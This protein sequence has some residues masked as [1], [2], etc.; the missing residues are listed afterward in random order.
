MQEHACSCTALLLLPEKRQKGISLRLCA[1][2]LGTR[3]PLRELSLILP[4]N[5]VDLRDALAVSF[6]GDFG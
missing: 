4:L 3:K 5:R 1:F 6:L 2:A